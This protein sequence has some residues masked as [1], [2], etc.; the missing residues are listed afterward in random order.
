MGLLVRESETSEVDFMQK[1]R[2]AV[3][4]IFGSLNNVPIEGEVTFTQKVSHFN[5]NFTIIH[6]KYQLIYRIYLWLSLKDLYMPVKLSINVNGLTTE[7]GRGFHVHEIGVEVNKQ[8]SP[9]SIIYCFL[10]C[11]Y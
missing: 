3:A 8:N 7:N 1:P 4:K 10:F 6:L 5:F 2:K 11:H 9:S